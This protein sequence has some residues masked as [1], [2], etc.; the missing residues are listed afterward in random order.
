MPLNHA[1]EARVGLQSAP[2]E[3]CLPILPEP[4]GTP[5]VGVVPQMAQTLL[6]EVR[7]EQLGSGGQDRVERLTSLAFARR[8]LPLG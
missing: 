3:L 4:P 1:H 8:R 5:F 6:Q 7:R 2:F